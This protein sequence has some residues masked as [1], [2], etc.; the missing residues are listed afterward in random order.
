VDVQCGF[1]VC[2]HV[3]V[4]ASLLRDWKKERHLVLDARDAFMQEL[5]SNSCVQLVLLHP[6]GDMH[7]FMTGA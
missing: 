7:L 4:H 1:H 3:D 6:I 2:S 5:I